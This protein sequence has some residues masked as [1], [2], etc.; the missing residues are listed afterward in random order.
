MLLFPVAARQGYKLLAFKHPRYL[1]SQEDLGGNSRIQGWHDHCP[2]VQ[3]INH[4]LQDEYPR[5]LLYLFATNGGVE[6]KLVAE[7]GWIV[8]IA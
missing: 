8:Y 6:L 5:T 3:V 4:R 7:R 1:F 2:S